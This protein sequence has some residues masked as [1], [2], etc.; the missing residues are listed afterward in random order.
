MLFLINY[1]M[2]SFT[3]CFEKALTFLQNSA[4]KNLLKLTHVLPS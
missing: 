1:A 4:Y 3:L 2:Y